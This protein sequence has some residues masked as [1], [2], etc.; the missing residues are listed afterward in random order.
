MK[1]Q[2]RLAYYLFGLLLGGVFV[3]WFLKAKAS[4]RGVEFCYLPNCRVLKDLRSKSLEIDSLAKQSLNEKWVTMEDIKNSLTYGDV[5]FEKS[6]EPYRKGKIYL[7][8]GK[9]SKNEDI[10]I[11]MVN[12]TNKVLL[13]KIE[14]K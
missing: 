2:F 10:T 1:F 13:E 3:M 9:T 12:Y 4:S 5:D 11:T 8:E 7:I 14:K 6:N